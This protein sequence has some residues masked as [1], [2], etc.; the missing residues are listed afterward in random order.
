MRERVVIVGVGLIGG[1]LGLALCGRGLAREV[2][3]VDP[4]GE[5]VRLALQAGAI[6]RAGGPEEAR[7]AGMVVVATP[8]GAIP[9]VLEELAPHLTPGTVVTDTGSVKGPVVEAA[10]RALPPEVGFVGGHPM[11][12]SE[13]AGMAGADR[14][15]FENAYYII[16]PTPGTPAWAVDRVAAM[17]EGVGARVVSMD[18]LHHDRLMAA[19]SH[20]P[21]LVAAALMSTVGR[22]P[23]RDE[24]LAL[25]AG[26]FR[27]TT[28]VAGSNPPLWEEIFRYNAPRLLEMLSL[29][30]AELDLLEGYIRRGDGPAVRHYLEEAAAARAALPAR[31]KGYLPCQYE[32]VITV[33]DRPGIIGEVGTHLGGEGINISDIEILRV[34]EGEG[35]TIRLAFAERASQERAVAV[36]L[37]RG[38]QAR[39][40]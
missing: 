27:D 11:A 5:N 35:V 38:I 22:R 40:P 4:D 30:R 24:M 12:G 19:V 2:V 6:H 36:L 13:H 28:R 21:H 34:R 17:A 16:T 15:L 25:A 33:P 1:S 10:F 18:P 9:R 14:Y 39:K 3:G 29:F 23:E 8:V 31:T 20:L 7:G 32:V 26:G 37:A